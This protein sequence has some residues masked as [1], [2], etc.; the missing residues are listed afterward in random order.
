MGHYG[1]KSFVRSFFKRKSHFS[2][3]RVC[4]ELL[5]GDGQTEMDDEQT[6]SGKHR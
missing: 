6:G 5:I 1:T 4:V 3:S 2:R